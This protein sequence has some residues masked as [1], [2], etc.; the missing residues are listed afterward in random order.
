MQG[1]LTFE[2]SHDARGRGRC[3][4]RDR[5]ALLASRRL[6]HVAPLGERVVSLA[7]ASQ[8]G[9]IFASRPAHRRSPVCRTISPPKSSMPLGHKP[10]EILDLILRQPKAELGAP[11]NNVADLFRPFLT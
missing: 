4:V 11:P 7:F 6:G 10:L 1:V 3:G 2:A 8:L 9:L 5:E